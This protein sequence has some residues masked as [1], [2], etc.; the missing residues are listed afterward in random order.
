MQET[1]SWFYDSQICSQICSDTFRAKSKFSFTVALPRILASH[2]DESSRRVISFAFILDSVRCIL[3]QCLVLCVQIC[4]VA[5]KCDFEREKKISLPY[6]SSY[7]KKA[8]FVSF[9]SEPHEESLRQN[10]SK[11]SFR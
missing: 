2:Q 10:G 11:T 5:C 9:A 7:P 4:R 1:I 3:E 8:T 6:F